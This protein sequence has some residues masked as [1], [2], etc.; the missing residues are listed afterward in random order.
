MGSRDLLCH[1]SGSRWGLSLH[2]ASLQFSSWVDRVDP[3]V[4][5]PILTTWTPGL[6]LEMAVELG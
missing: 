5:T 4:G 1:V 3:N 6:P 2:V